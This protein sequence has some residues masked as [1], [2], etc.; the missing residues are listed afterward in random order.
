MIYKLDT[1]VCDNIYPSTAQTW[2]SAHYLKCQPLKFWPG[3]GF[4][5]TT[6][7]CKKTASLV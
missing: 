6:S 4:P 3:Y 7:N 5:A 2:T 1:V